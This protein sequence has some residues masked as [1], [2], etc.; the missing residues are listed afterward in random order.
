M[1]QLL[2]GKKEFLTF[3]VTDVKTHE[4]LNIH[5]LAHSRRSLSN[6]YILTLI[7]LLRSIKIESAR[8]ELECGVGTLS[9]V[10][11]TGMSPSSR[12]LECLVSSWELLG[13]DQMVKY[14]WR[15]CHRGEILRLQKIHAI[16]SALSISCLLLKV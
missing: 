14:C 13:Q 3:Q 4:Y 5:N 10:C 6:T 1:C 12:G 8:E 2:G 7:L 9:V 16:P 11:L 15:E